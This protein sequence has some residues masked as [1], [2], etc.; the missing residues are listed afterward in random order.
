VVS[1]EY[2]VEDG[3]GPETI[4]LS[5]TL[6]DGTYRVYAMVYSG[7]PD[8][9][10]EAECGAARVSVYSE[11]YRQGPL[12]FYEVGRETWRD[13]DGNW[14]QVFNLHVQNRQVTLQAIDRIVT[15]YTDVP[16]YTY[17]PRRWPGGVQALARTSPVKEELMMY[18]W[19][20]RLS[21]FDLMLKLF[22]HVRSIAD[23]R[24]VEGATYSL[25]KDDEVIV[26]D[27]ASLQEAEM[28]G[29]DLAPG[30][31]RIKISA[32]MYVVLQTC[33]TM[34]PARDRLKHQTFW[35]AP[36]DNK[37]RAVVRWRS[38]PR[39]LDLYVVPVG[40]G[41]LWKDV[42]GLLATC[43]HV[44]PQNPTLEQGVSRIGIERSSAAHPASQ[45]AESD[46]HEFG[47][48]SITISGAVPGQYRIFVQAPPLGSQIPVLAGGV[49]ET[50]EE[51]VYVD[52]Y[53]DSMYYTTLEF[54]AGYTKWWYVGYFSVQPASLE[55]PQGTMT[56]MTESRIVTLYDPIDC[57]VS[58]LVG[59]FFD[60]E[61]AGKY[62]SETDF[63]DLRYTVMR[64]DY[65]GRLSAKRAD[66]TR[67]RV[68]ACMCRRADET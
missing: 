16:S 6:P 9:T 17:I 23:D 3:F 35:L 49:G 7:H 58:P 24:L 37:V 11:M 4:S 15:G 10:F 60:I 38:T 27:G 65:E 42:N 2:D 57:V 26:P 67:R 47:P 55:N 5:G 21:K 54:K 25:W 14:W 33:V 52:I 63:S 31:Y 34:N 18:R 20:E 8:S 51:A 1:L 59:L 50:C 56:W 45:P 12:F 61:S 40:T 13:K 19:E 32:L 22:P 48:K 29:I 39:E 43:S 64:V 62:T 44:G 68:R 46:G 41:L 28:R 36:A 53:M 66:I 30:E